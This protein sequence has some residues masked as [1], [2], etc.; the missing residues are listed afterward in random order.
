MYFYT[1]VNDFIENIFESSNN[2]QY[3]GLRPR[4]ETK[5]DNKSGKY[6]QCHLLVWHD[7]NLP[8]ERD[9]QGFDSETLTVAVHSNP[10]CKS[11]TIHQA[12]PQFQCQQPPYVIVQNLR[13]DLA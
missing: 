8:I 12:I 10:T 13:F 7:T 2:I 6:C 4:E 5:N 3:K 9:N 11:T 1:I